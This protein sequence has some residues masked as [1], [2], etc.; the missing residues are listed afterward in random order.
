[1]IMSSL[2]PYENQIFLDLLNNDGMFYNDLADNKN[3]RVTRITSPN[4]RFTC[5]GR[6]PRN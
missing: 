5:Y 4:N 1:M 6:R 2:L 3:F